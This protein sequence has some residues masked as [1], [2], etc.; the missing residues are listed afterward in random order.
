MWVFPTPE[1]VVHK[2]VEGLLHVAAHEFFELTLVGGNDFAP[3]YL[4]V[5]FVLQG[6]SLV[7]RP[8][9]ALE[10]DAGA[11]VNLEIGQFLAARCLGLEFA[12]IYF[13]DANKG[14]V[15]FLA[16]TRPICV[17]TFLYSSS[18]ITRP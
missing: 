18:P 12:V 10:V 3:P 13:C 8:H 6:P 14:V 9:F 1:F 15:A 17:P 11:V 16:T 5:V 2:A 4:E 7:L